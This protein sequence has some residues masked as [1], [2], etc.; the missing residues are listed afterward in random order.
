L[1][2][3]GSYLTVEALD[4]IFVAR[5]TGA[6]PGN[7]HVGATLIAALKQAPPAGDPLIVRC[8][9]KRVSIGSVR[10]EC[11]WQPVSAA[12]VDSPAASDWLGALAMSYSM[13]RGRIATEELANAVDDAQRKLSQLVARV[14]ESLAPVGVTKEDVRS[15]VESRLR[16]RYGGRQAEGAT[17]DEQ[18]VAWMPDSAH[19]KDM[20]GYAGT[21][22]LGAVLVKPGK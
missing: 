2:F 14:A 12:L 11:E 4:Q 8:D 17:G 7:A 16:E 19:A 22:A 10:I 21:A 13:P 15:L 3:D 20:T 9:G 1:G 18:L 5:A 6:W